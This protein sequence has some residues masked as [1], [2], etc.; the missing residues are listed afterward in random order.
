[1]AHWLWEDSLRLGHRG[2]SRV[3]SHWTPFWCVGLFI[4]ILQYMLPLTLVDSRCPS[5]LLL[6]LAWSVGFGGTTIVLKRNLFTG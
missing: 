6:K 5:N 3:E 1:M 2:G 4:Y